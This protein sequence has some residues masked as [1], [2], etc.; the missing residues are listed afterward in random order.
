MPALSSISYYARRAAATT[1]KEGLFEVIRRALKLADLNPEGFYL[2][3]KYT[4]RRT[5]RSYRHE[6]DP[7]ATIDVDPT[8]IEYKPVKNWSK[9]GHMGDVRGGD[10]DR[11]GTCFLDTALYQSLKAHFIDGVAWEDTEKY[12][13]ALRQ[14]D[15]GES[16]W[17][18]SFNVE[19]VN[20]RCEHLDDLFETIRD[21]G[22]KSQ[23]EIHGKPNREV[24]LSRK[25]DHFMTDVV[26]HISRNGQF[27]FCDGR[28]RFT[29]ARI[30]GLDS[31]PVRVVV[32]HE[33]WQEI[34]EEIGGAESVSELSDQARQHLDH[35][36]VQD[37]LP[38][39][40]PSD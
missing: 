4:L 12:Q 7:Y 5:F 34:R 35:P 36:D 22:F 18:R 13:E 28:H 2:H 6:A 23:S 8:Q 31:I 21:E 39:S 19:E 11:L 10:W 40:D 3:G 27:L 32:R 37:L 16:A 20:E 33:Q 38:L 29:I 26:V 15:V 9:W 1:R 14:I 24:V 25:W 17:N 30:L